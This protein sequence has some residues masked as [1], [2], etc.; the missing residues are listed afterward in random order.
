MVSCADALAA[1]KQWLERLKRLYIHIIFGNSQI[2]RLR[3]PYVIGVGLHI[4]L[5]AFSRVTG[6]MLLDIESDGGAVCL[7]RAQSASEP[8]LRLSRS[9]G[10]S[11]WL[12]AFVGV[13]QLG[14][15][16][17]YIGAAGTVVPVDHGGVQ[18][19]PCVL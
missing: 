6:V 3:G 14:P 2:A 1:E 9:R 12:R 4:L 16:I 10:M 19:R 5:K 15:A 17:W 7:S 11:I 18:R 13:V 8:Q